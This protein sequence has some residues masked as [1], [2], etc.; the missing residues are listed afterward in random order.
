MV[1]LCAKNLFDNSTMDTTGGWKGSKKMVKED[2]AGKEN[3]HLLVTAKKRDA[4]SFS[5]EVDTKGVFSLTVKLRYR[6]KDYV[7]RGFEFRGIRLGGGSTYFDRTFTADGQWH[8][9]T[10]NFTQVQGS[11]KINFSFIVLQGEGEVCFDDITVEA[12]K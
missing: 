10:L 12:D 2:D 9:M 6:T 3:R 8:E 4:V 7:G 5:Q 1:P 11:K